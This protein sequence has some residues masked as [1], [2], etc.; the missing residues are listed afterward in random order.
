VEPPGG[1]V[2]G[3]ALPVGTTVA[4]ALGGAVVGAGL[5]VG[6]CVGWALDDGAEVG[7]AAGATVV[8]AA[9]NTAAKP[10]A[11]DRSMIGSP[12]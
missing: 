10:R 9:T 8:Q 7:E 4:A 1:A 5:A 12:K 11:T 3:A 6:A 2:V